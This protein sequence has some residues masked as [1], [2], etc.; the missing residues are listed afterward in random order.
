MDAASRKS[1]ILCCVVEQYIHTAEPIGSKQLLESTGL[2]VSSATVR[3]DMAAL[4]QDG[5]L[6]QPHTSAGR[7]PTQEGYRHYLDVMPTSIEPPA[8][9]KML[10]FRQM[11]SSADDPEHILDSAAKTL[12]Q[13]TGFACVATTPPPEAVKIAKIR[14][15]QTGRQTAMTVLVTSSGMIKYRLFRCD[16]MLTPELVKV[17]ERL[18]NESLTGLAPEEVTPA[19]IQSLAAGFGELAMLMPTVL[20]TIMEQCGEINSMEIKKYGESNLLFCNDFHLDDLRGIIKLLNSS[21]LLA[22]VLLRADMNSGIL[23]G[24]ETKIP[25]LYKCA[26]IAK[27]YTVE[28]QPSG[29]LGIIAPLRV[30]YRKNLGRLEYVSSVVGKLIN[31]LLEA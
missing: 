24:T 25:E 13:M 22:H 29:A 18:L 14:L 6:Y 16:Y 7:I 31:G 21:E 26:V 28:S 3:N 23:L 20:I 30:D 17:F 2:K 8:K 27:R 5:F 9:E 11:S 10:A 1:K 12:S 19:F 4:S 15:V